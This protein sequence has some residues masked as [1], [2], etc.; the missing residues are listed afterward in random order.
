MTN[1][2]LKHMLRGIAL[3]LFSI[4]MFLIF[5]WLGVILAVFSALLSP[6]LAISPVAAIITPVHLTSNSSGAGSPPH[7]P[8]ARLLNSQPQ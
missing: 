1:M 8:R 2:D 4:P 6:A 7:T 3:I 5:F